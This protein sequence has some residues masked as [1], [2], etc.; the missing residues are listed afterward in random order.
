VNT[1]NPAKITKHLFMVYISKSFY[2]AY[3][4]IIT[5]SLQETRVQRDKNQ[6]TMSSISCF[7]ADVGLF[8]TYDRCQV[9]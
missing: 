6:K 4:C 7:T 2:S 8:K 5:F 1:G 9:K 3:E